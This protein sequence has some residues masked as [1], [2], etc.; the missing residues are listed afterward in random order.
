MTPG[1][2]KTATLRMWQ[3]NTVSLSSLSSSFVAGGGGS[4]SREQSLRVAQLEREVE[5]LKEVLAREQAAESDP[6]QAKGLPMIVPESMEDRVGMLHACMHAKAHACV[7]ACVHACIGACM[8]A[9]THAW[10]Y[11]WVCTWMHACM[12]NLIG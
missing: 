8:H 11:L 5:R 3:E 10:E 4:R 1:V 2:L 12:Y 7:H 9:C 6:E